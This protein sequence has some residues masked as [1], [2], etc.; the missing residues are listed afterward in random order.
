MLFT[1]EAS[2][3]P[4]LSRHQ[5]LQLNPYQHQHAKSLNLVLNLFHFHLILSESIYLNLIVKCTQPLVFAI[6]QHVKKISPLCQLPTC[7]ASK[8]YP[9]QTPWPALEL[10]PVAVS[11]LSSEGFKIYEYG[12]QGVTVKNELWSLSCCQL[13]SLRL[14][15]VTRMIKHGLQFSISLKSDVHW[16]LSTSSPLTL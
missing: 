6:Y 9:C 15:C 7:L 10:P 3:H 14:C 12:Q 5:S 1:L 16:T 4:S 11:C 8:S 13:L 2:S